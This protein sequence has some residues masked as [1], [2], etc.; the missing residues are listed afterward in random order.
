[1]N[2]E[3]IYNRLITTAQTRGPNDGYTETHHIIPKCMGGTDDGANLVELR[4]DEHYMAHLLLMKMNPDHLGLVVKAVNCMSMNSATHMRH[5][6][7]SFRYARE[8][9]SKLQSG[10]GNHFYGKKHT[11]ET[12]KKISAAHKG[13]IVSE[14]TREKLRENGLKMVFSEEHRRKISQGLSGERNGMYGV[15]H[16]D[17]TKKILSEMTLARDL[18]GSRN[19]SAHPVVIDGIKYG[20]KKDAADA[21]GIS[22]YKL[23]N[24]L[25]GQ[26][27]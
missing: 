22:M 25:K 6:N 10:E 4:A 3:K 27:K 12:K 1:M 16:S 26:I 11:E 17:E 13:K 18:S 19:P 21:L 24:L 8:R 23:R 2:Y 20:C 15:G 9:M 14:S 7:K 5:T